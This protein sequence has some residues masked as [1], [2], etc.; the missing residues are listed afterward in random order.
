MKKFLTTLC[1]FSI[2]AV[3]PLWA[4]LSFIEENALILKEKLEADGNREYQRLEPGV[5][6]KK[7]SEEREIKLEG[8]NSYAIIGYCD[9]GC[10]D[11]DLELMNPEREILA[12]DKQ[13]DDFPV[14]EFDLEEDGTFIVSVDMVGCEGAE[15][16]YGLLIYLKSDDPADAVPVVEVFEE[17]RNKLLDRGWGMVAERNGRID[18]EGTDNSVEFK[19]KKDGKYKIVGV[20]DG[21]CS[22]LNLCL[23]DEKGKKIDCDELDDDTPIVDISP[24]KSGT[25]RVEATM[26]G[27]RT[28]DCGFSVALFEDTGDALSMIVAGQLDKIYEALELER[29][30]YDR[31]RSASL[32]RGA[33]RRFDYEFERGA[34]TV[35]VGVC[36]DQCEDINLTMYDKKG[37]VLLQDLA[38]DDLP[39]LE[40]GPMPGQKVTIEITMVKCKA[41]ACDVGVEML[42]TN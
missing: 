29:I 22:D 20:C 32:E 24:K 4:Q 35:F 34:G 10:S 28:D 25:Y 39:V 11:L 16:Y 9:N 27:C 19:L 3:G 26:V 33:S 30:N 18:A 6:E 23:Y 2:C 13:D 36:D 1:L 15:C 17:V 12:S 31:V 38:D 40:L 8:G 42:E 41:K 7:G 37:K 14:L 21:N 5:L